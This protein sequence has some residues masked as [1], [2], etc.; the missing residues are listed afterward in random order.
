MRLLSRFASLV[1][2]V[3]ALSIGVQAG[4]ITPVSADTKPIAITGNVYIHSTPDTS[5]STRLTIMQKGSQPDYVCYTRAEDVGGTNVW[6]RVRWNGVEGFYSSYL[7]D[8]PL[9][10]QSNLE[11]NYGIHY[12]GTGSEMNQGAGA[13]GNINLPPGASFNY[14]RG[15]AARWALAHAKDAQSLYWSECAWFV[16]NSLWNGGFA[17]NSE[18]NGQGSHGRVRKVP[19]TV[20]ATSAP[21]LVKYLTNTGWAT[22]SPITSNLST[23]AVP[24]AQPGDVIAYDWTGDDAIDHVA[25]VVDIAAG[26][27]PEVAEWG[28][29]K[30]GQSRST[31]QKRGWTYSE[32]SH[33][34]LQAEPKHGGMKAYLLHI[35]F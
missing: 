33:G 6:F 29:T 15:A 7:D 11:G 31:Y 4:G 27:Y 23:N 20:I 10:A 8:V 16:S 18:W 5:T 9:S 30:P 12:C 25:L 26:S 24:D 13:N 19:G 35:N 1:A 2:A 17:Q 21:N 14:D 32:N 34:W 3:A 28:T 22:Q